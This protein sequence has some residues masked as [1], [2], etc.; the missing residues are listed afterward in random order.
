M[1]RLKKI[2]VVGVL[3][4]GSVALGLYFIQE[5]IIFQPEYLSRTHIYNFDHPFKEFFLI[6]KDSSELNAI[7]FTNSRPKGVILYFHGNKGNLKRWGQ[8]VLF[9]AKKGYDVVVMDYRGYGKST[10]KISEKCLYEDAQL[11]YEYLLKQYTEDQII[12]YGRSLGTGIAT[13][14]ASENTPSSLILETPY[15]NLED[16]AKN[17][18]PIFPIKSLLRYEIPTMDFIQNITCPVT[19]FHGTNDKVV[20]Y[21]S[22]K[23]LFESLHTDTSK[24]RMITIPNGSHNNLITFTEYLTN[25]D[26]ILEKKL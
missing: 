14:I 6:A 16:V 24:K 4:Y 12:V 5:R 25:I 10:G 17:W 22:G 18:L 26:V 20:P 21:N 13:K 9:F 7:H 23:R 1:L 8:I 19:I 3:F 15:Y 11:F 2:I